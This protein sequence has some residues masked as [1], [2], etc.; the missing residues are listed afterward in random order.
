MG[1]RQCCIRE[2]WSLRA[3]EM[4]GILIV[5]WKR[6]LCPEKENRQSIIIIHDEKYLCSRSES[7]N[8]LPKQILRPWK[9]TT[10][11][12]RIFDMETIHSISLN[13]KPTFLNRNFSVTFSI[14]MTICPNCGGLRESQISFFPVSVNFSTALTLGKE[15]YVL[16][17]VWIWNSRML[18]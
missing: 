4:M 10:L 14:T 12:R 2:A 7:F 18:G 17:T 13:C 16:E 11:A 1:I 6:G 15:N 3:H 8:Y 5:T 9:Q